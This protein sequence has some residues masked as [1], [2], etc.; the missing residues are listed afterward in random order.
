MLAEP[1]LLALG[2]CSE[3][4]RD[5]AVDDAVGEAKDR[6]SAELEKQLPSV[7]W[8]KY[9]DGAQEEIDRAAAA[10]DCDT[11]A[12]ELAKIDDRNS[13]LRDYIEVKLRDAGC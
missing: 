13:P 11:L 8:Q 10:A 1:L 3:E 7:D 5:R 2:A 6:A 9:R 12:D 4:A